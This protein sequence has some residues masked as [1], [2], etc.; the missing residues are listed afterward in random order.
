MTKPTW[1]PEALAIV[2]GLETNC[3][4]FIDEACEFVATKT[5]APEVTTEHVATVLAWM[6]TVSVDLGSNERGTA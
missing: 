6:A 2:R 5:G 4:D 3:A 1:T